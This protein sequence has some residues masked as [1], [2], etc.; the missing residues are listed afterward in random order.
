L[1]SIVFVG[2]IVNENCIMNRFPIMN[3]FGIW[4]IWFV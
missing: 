2:P 3:G 1:K 4:T